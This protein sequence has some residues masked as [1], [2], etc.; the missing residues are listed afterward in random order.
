ML[1]SSRFDLNLLSVLEAVLTEGSVVKA[2]NRLHITPSAVSNA[3]ARLRLIIGDPLVTRRGR[4]IVP[5]P[6]ALELA[7]LLARTLRELR[8]A[9]RTGAF[10]PA[11]T[12][13]RFTLALSDA[14]QIALLPAIAALSARRMPRASLRAV[15]IDA[16][17]LLGGLGGAE[18]DVVIG[19][20]KGGGEIHCEALFSQPAVLICRKDHPA[21]EAAREPRRAE[22]LRHIAIEMAPGRALPDLAGLAYRKARIARDVAMT[23]PTFSAA[24]AVVA[25]TDF[26]ATV[27]AAFY[28]AVS[29]RMGISAL[30]FPMPQLTIPTN[31]CWHERTHADSSAGAF[32]DV[33]R[34]AA[35]SAAA[36]PSAPAASRAT[37]TKR[38]SRNTRA[39]IGPS[40]ARG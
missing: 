30:P 25:A 17:V 6:R 21:L 34:Q 39:G 5:T 16:L 9:V 11:T 26:V 38:G 4:G 1:S 3:L 33:I 14:S 18:V 13:K 22:A 29:Q 12:A 27:P 40:R 35:K 20:D 37:P 28:S 2:A 23:V 7:P 10:D 8:E 31:M 24:A 36:G 32:R 19:P 15:G